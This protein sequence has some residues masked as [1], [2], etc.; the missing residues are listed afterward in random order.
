MPVDVHALPEVYFVRLLSL[1]I[2]IVFILFIGPSGV[3][4]MGC[5][6]LVTGMPPD[7]VVE[8]GFLL[9]RS[10]LSF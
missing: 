5:P 3:V 2:D 4:L 7:T 1:N 8:M 6:Y 10:S 9:F